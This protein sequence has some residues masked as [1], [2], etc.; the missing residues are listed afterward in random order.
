MVVQSYLGYQVIFLGEA[1]FWVHPNLEKTLTAPRSASQYH[2]VIVA[3]R[4]WVMT[5]FE[6]KL[7]VRKKKN[8]SWPHLVE[9]KQ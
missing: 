8:A 3:E 1:R 2:F 6:E 4:D 7:G 9:T 5:R